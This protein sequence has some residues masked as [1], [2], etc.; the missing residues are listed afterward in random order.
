[1]PRKRTVPLSDDEIRARRAEYQRRWRAKQRATKTQKGSL[2]PPSEDVLY[3]PSTDGAA[4][5]ATVAALVNQKYGYSKIIGT[6][7]RGKQTIIAERLRR[8]EV[9]APH[10]RL[11]MTTYLFFESEGALKNYALKNGIPISYI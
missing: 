8:T 5:P 3:E 4:D 7:H 1:M 11:K 10:Y 9:D 2:Y 6:Y